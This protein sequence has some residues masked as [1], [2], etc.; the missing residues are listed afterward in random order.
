[1]LAGDDLG[2]HHALALPLVGEHRRA[3][4][5]ADGVDALGD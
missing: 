2:D 3:G 1:M 5:V 4:D